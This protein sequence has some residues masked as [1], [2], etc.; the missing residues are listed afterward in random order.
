VLTAGIENVPADVPTKKKFALPK[1]NSKWFFGTSGKTTFIGAAIVLLVICFLDSFTPVKVIPAYAKH[2]LVSCLI[3]AILALGLNF[4][5]G[6]IGQTS[7]GHAAFFGIGAYGTA[8]LMKYAGIDFWFTIP[9]AACIAALAALPLAASALRVKGSFL[10][11]ITY[12]FG[13]VL[14]Y[15]AINTDSLGGSSG[16]PG[17]KAPTIFGMKMSKI[18]PTGKEGYLILCFLI[19]ALLAFFM[20]RIEKSRTGYAFAAIREDEIAAVAMGIH[21]KY[22]KILAFVISAF[23]CSIAGSIQVAYSSFVS[24][25]LLTSTQSILI[26]TMVIVGGRRSIKGAILGAGL[27]TILPEILHSIKDAIGLPFDP[28]YNYWAEWL[29]KDHILQSSD[30]NCSGNFRAGVF[31]REKYYP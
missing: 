14:R 4:V 21:T 27:M 18:G 31:R 17:I 19:V 26:L 10:V 29:R 28:W 9:I 6:Y 25:E 12:G 22:Y 13:E 16:I 11:V 5:S 7:L 24:P 1:G 2:I 8:V 20:N 23:I 30:R 15:V 3:Y